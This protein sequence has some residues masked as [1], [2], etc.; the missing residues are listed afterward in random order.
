MTEIAY[1][2]LLRSQIFGAERSLLFVNGPIPQDEGFAHDHDF[3]EI[4]VIASGYGVHVSANGVQ[5]ISR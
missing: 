2:R 1:G 5:P 4:V 3:L